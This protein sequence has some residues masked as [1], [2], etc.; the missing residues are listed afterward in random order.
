MQEVML[1]PEFRH[2]LTQ[3]IP[4]SPEGLQT[5]HMYGLVDRLGNAVSQQHAAGDVWTRY[6]ASAPFLSE[7][8]QFEWPLAANSWIRFM[9]IFAQHRDGEHQVE[10]LL[11][12]VFYLYGDVLQYSYIFRSIGAA[13]TPENIQLVA[14]TLQMYPLNTEI[15]FIGCAMLSVMYFRNTGCVPGQLETC[16]AHLQLALSILTREHRDSRSL[17]AA[18]HL[19]VSMH[20]MFQQDVEVCLH[21]KQCN[22][23]LLVFDAQDEIN[24]DINLIHAYS[25]FCVRF[26]STWTAPV[27]P[28]GPPGRLPLDI[29]IDCMRQNAESS[30]HIDTGCK[31][32]ELLSIRNAGTLAISQQHMAFLSTLV[33]QVNANTTRSVKALRVYPVWN[34]LFHCVTTPAAFATFR[35]AFKIPLLLQTL[36][37][38]TLGDGEENSVDEENPRSP[39]IGQYVDRV[40]HFLRHVLNEPSLDKRRQ[41]LENNGVGVL[42][43]VVAY[44]Y[45]KHMLRHCE[46]GRLAC[47]DMFLDLFGTPE[48]QLVAY[49]T[50]PARRGAT[51]PVNFTY[52]VAGGAQVK[53]T[54]PNFLLDTLVYT[55]S[56]YTIVFT[57]DSLLMI[58]R[59]LE[60]LYALSQTGDLARSDGRTLI[61]KLLQFAHEMIPRVQAQAHSLAS[62][63]LAGKLVARMDSILLQYARYLTPLNRAL[64]AQSDDMR[65]YLHTTAMHPARGTDFL[66]LFSRHAE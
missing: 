61:T 59:I 28:P 29:I 4:L 22:L 17:V 64:A 52:S 45:R 15:Q 35:R 51:V 24:D 41:F 32:L 50:M 21:A 1:L 49:L 56:L 14:S 54:F 34:M 25:M 62:S 16:G 36:S 30:M 55:N 10:A 12:R 20:F 63:Q 40:L 19:V 13:S 27:L 60:L 48:H 46:A 23:V 44:S 39:K 53:S 6:V 3:H 26:L 18:I 66:A 42:V 65:Q 57:A 33:A 37:H 38:L 47:V 9:E 8:G 2:A 5:L 31:Q 58:Q 7:V 43:D 11:R